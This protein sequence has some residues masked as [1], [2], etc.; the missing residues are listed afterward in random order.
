MTA[1]CRS[2]SVA[3]RACRIFAS[4]RSD[5]RRRGKLVRETVYLYPDEEEML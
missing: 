4:V 5:G 3:P 1:G 2:T